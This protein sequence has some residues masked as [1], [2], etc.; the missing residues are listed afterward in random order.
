MTNELMSYD[1]C[2]RCRA[3]YRSFEGRGGPYGGGG[4]C[5]G[6]GV[7][8]SCCFLVVQMLILPNSYDDRSKLRPR[9]MLL[10]LQPFWQ[11]CRRQRCRGQ[12]QMQQVARQRR[13]PQWSP[14]LVWPVSLL[15]IWRALL[16]RHVPLSGHV[17]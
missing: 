16:P 10:R 2:C 13:L 8:T 6:G 5:S 14:E 1:A 17:R 3:L 4:T 9:L 7:C 12:L 15:C 11:Q